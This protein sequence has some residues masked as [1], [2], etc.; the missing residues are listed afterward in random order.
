MK[1][2]KKEDQKNSTKTKDE[3]DEKVDD[4][5]LVHN[6]TEGGGESKTTN[7]T[8][9]HNVIIHHHKAFMVFDMLKL[10]FE[11]AK[12]GSFSNFFGLYLYYPKIPSYVLS[13]GH[14]TPAQAK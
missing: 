14:K 10:K 9:K 11:N 3:I 8:E 2:T 7:I 12:K 5:N 4:G 1:P 13:P 6:K